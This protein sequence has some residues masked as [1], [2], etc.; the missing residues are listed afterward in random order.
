MAAK[1]VLCAICYKTHQRKFFGPAREAITVDKVILTFR[2]SICMRDYIH[3]RGG[4]AFC[5]KP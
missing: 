4:T 3:A 5:H 2:S 1:A